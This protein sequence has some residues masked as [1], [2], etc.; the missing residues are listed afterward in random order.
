MDAPFARVAVAGTGLIGGSFA[1][2]ARQA[3]PGV[4][5]AGWDRPAV[6]HEALERGIIDTAHAQLAEAL[7]GAELIFVAL[8]GGV[9]IEQLPAIARD[10]AAN[11]LVTDAASTKREV[12]A[13]A[14]KCFGG[15]ARFLGGHPMAGNEVSGLSSA[16]AEL[17]C[18]A[19]YALVETRESNDG[20]DLATRARD[21]A[22]A[23]TGA[24]K[25]HA[26]ESRAIKPHSVNNDPRLAKFV[27]LVEAMGARPLWM[28]PQTHDRAAAF[29]SH[30][31]QLLAV[32]LGGVVGA[33]ADAT[34]LPLALAGRGL[35]DMLRLAG[36]PYAVWR[37]ILLTNTDNVDLALA[38]LCQAIEH[39]RLNLRSRELQGEFATANDVYK[40]LRDLQ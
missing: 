19:S 32:A 25:P 34:G 27:Q 10:A 8:P 15:G 23:G 38:R 12:C 24:T 36:S 40:V 30:L 26:I 17:F 9:T 6:L 7:A 22:G 1:L 31:P 4:R 20:T 21:A 35:R 11:A 39:L 29:V 2:A 13:A 28:D 3:L 33:E 14:Q 37:D 18:G 16:S 5:I